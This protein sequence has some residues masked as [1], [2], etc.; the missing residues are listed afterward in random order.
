MSNG[1][2]LKGWLTTAAAVAGGLLLRKMGR[3]DDDLEQRVN[4][5]S[6]TEAEIVLQPRYE[7]LVTPQGRLT[8]NLDNITFGSFLGSPYFRQADDLFRNDPQWPTP[9]GKDFLAA[10]EDYIQ[11]DMKSL[12]P[13][14]HSGLAGYRHIN[15]DITEGLKV[16][17]KAELPLDTILFLAWLAHD[18]IE[19]DPTIN[20]Y[21]DKWLTALMSGD[22]DNLQHYGNLLS[23][24]REKLRKDLRKKLISLIPTGVRGYERELYRDQ[25]IEKA[26]K[27]VFDVTRFTE[28][29]PY[30]FSLR[31]QYTRDGSEG[32]NQT[33]RR[34]ILKDAD[35]R[36]NAYE[37]DPVNEEVKQQMLLASNDKSIVIGSANGNDISYVVGEE[38]SRR[39]GQLVSEGTPMVAAKRLANVVN[40]IPGLQ[41]GNETIGSYGEGISSGRHNGEAQHLSRLAV[42]SRFETVDALVKL[43]KSA[44]TLYLQHPEV[45]DVVEEVDKD[46][47]I[48][49]DGT[50]FDRATINGFIG[51]WI[52]MDAEGRT[53]DYDATS[54]KRV[55]NYKDTREALEL[56]PRFSMVRPVDNPSKI[57][58]ISPKEYDPKKHILFTVRDFD[59]IERGFP[60]YTSLLRQRGR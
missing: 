34:I 43:L 1:D 17:L 13:R 21:Y 51:R 56:V 10:V 3:G 31:H 36:S 24:E 5:L 44:I 27:L 28:R 20:L 14:R 29:N 49:R 59:I 26:V 4:A 12:G 55:A 8:I 47:R 40:A 33:H 53:R 19:D 52:V 39:F 58:T 23:L 37:V 25:Y 48:K 30:V 32:L 42:Y 22:R 45:R 41:Y 54:E 57:I 6:K 15:N 50:Y 2:R 38:L 11:S 35:I 60:D 46:I 7:V 16:S 9:V 18:K